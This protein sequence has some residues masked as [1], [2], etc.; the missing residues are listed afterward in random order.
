MDAAI[1][2]GI[3]HRDQI[4]A[5]LPEHADAQSLFDFMRTS[6][7]TPAIGLDLARHPWRTF[8]VAI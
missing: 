1:K 7:V 8:L 2:L 6:P 5:V 3:I 4:V